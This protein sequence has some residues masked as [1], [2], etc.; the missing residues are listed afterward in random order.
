MHRESLVSC[1][2]IGQ[3]PSEKRR[4]FPT[5]LLLPRRA[6]SL[7]SLSL[8]SLH[9]S[10]LAALGSGSILPRHRPLSLTGSQCPQ[11]FELKSSQLSIFCVVIGT[12]LRG[13]TVFAVHTCS[14]FRLVPLHGAGCPSDLRKKVIGG[15]VG[16]S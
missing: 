14:L 2:G 7:L 5:L 3:S 13:F 9:S 11:V 6:T 16:P 1:G 4:V 8:S 12:S 10:T 15:A